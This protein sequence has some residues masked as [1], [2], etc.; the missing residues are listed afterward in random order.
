MSSLC[1][2]PLPSNSEAVL[3]LVFGSNVAVSKVIESA[4]RFALLK[5][6]C[7]LISNEEASSIVL[8][9]EERLLKEAI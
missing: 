1:V 8:Q 2:G 7:G 4:K 3:R 6:E 9:L 5:E